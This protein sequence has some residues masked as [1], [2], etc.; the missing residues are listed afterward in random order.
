MKH[1][2]RQVAYPFHEPRECVGVRFEGMDRC[3]RFGHSRCINADICTQIQSYIPRTQ[4]CKP[5]IEFSLHR[6]L[7]AKP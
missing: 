6:G 2:I 1:N 4:R 3:T 7:I 5:C